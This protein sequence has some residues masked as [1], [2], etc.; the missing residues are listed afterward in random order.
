MK[1]DDDPNV[2]SSSDPLEVQVEKLKAIAKEQEAEA[3]I[4]RE[5][6]V[7]AAER[8]DELSTTIQRLVEATANMG[9]AVTSLCR[10]DS[11]DRSQREG[12]D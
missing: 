3:D 2:V 8:I 7:A 6:A 4:W 12:E 5:R 11:T 1:P 9:I 10:A